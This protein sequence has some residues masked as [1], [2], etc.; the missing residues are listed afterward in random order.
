[1]RSAR[2]SLVAN[3]ELALPFIRKAAE[4]AVQPCWQLHASTLSAF[5]LNGTRSL[6]D[7]LQ[8]SSH[9][10]LNGRAA[11]HRMRPAGDDQ[12]IVPQRRAGADIPCLGVD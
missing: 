8:C 11:A 3:D 9:R 7:P 10:N 1:V 12:A 4:L 6:C 2:Q 5:T